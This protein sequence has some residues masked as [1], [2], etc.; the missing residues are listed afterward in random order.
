MY[1]GQMC[2]FF[3]ATSQRKFTILNIFRLQRIAFNFRIE[4]NQHYF[5]QS[6]RNGF[7]EIYIYNIQGVP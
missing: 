3:V 2:V 1:F 4:K 5:A 6:K 7:Y